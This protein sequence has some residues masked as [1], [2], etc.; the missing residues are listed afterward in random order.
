MGIIWTSIII[1]GVIGLMAAALL[2]VAARKFH[3]EEDP[4]IAEVEALLPGANCGGCGKNGCHDLAAACC[5][6][7]SLDGLACPGAGADTMKR[8]AQIVGLVAEAT[9]PHVAVVKCNGT[10]DARPVRVDYQGPRTCAAIA[11]LGA[12]TT[13]CAWGCL[14]CGDCVKACRFGALSIDS[15]TGLPVIDESKCTGCGVCLKACPRNV[16]ELRPRG[17]RGLRVWVACNNRERGAVARKECS[18]ACIGCGKCERT[19]SHGAITVEA[20]LAYI[21]AGKCR[22][23]RKCVDVCPTGAILTANFPK[24]KTEQSRETE[25][26]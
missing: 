19:C 3:V 25:N 5:K 10:C 20:N 16:I 1:L 26:V 9:E 21:D 4:R 2:W 15:A 14:G 17:R 12:G 6:A 11:L 18:A 22:L 23:C 13:A 7:T 24:P 8:I